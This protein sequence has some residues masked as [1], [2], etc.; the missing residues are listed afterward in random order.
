MKLLS[1]I[2]LN[3][4]LEGFAIPPSPPES[5]DSDVEVKKP[6]KKPTTTSLIDD[7]GWNSAVFGGIIKVS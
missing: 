7:V 3:L 6:A 1:L 4:N 5:S 2:S